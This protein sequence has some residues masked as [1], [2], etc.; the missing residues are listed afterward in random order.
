MKN[1]LQFIGSFHT[2][3]SERQAVQLV[4][5]LKKDAILSGLLFTLEGSLIGEIQEI[6]NLF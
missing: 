4:Q 5:L 1:V 3:G 2:G 6:K